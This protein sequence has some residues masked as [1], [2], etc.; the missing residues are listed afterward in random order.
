MDSLLIER[1]AYETNHDKEIIW[2]NVSKDGRSYI[3]PCY[4]EK[5]RDHNAY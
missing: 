3:D 1:L 4:N 5:S 2:T